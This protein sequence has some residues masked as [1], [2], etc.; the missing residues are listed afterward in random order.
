MRLATSRLKILFSGEEDRGEANSAACRNEQTP[1]VSRP[2]GQLRVKVLILLERIVECAS[3][4]IRLSAES[5]CPADVDEIVGDDAQAN[6][7]LDAVV[8]FVTA[9]VESVP[10]LEDTNPTFASCSPFL[11]V[12]EPPL[13]LFPLTSAFLVE[14]LGMQTR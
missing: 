4:E 7:T 2:A 10:P 3:R 8:A 14:R 12:A 13:L 1:P 6:P 5:H 11:P 9:A